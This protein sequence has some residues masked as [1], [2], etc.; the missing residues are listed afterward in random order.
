MPCNSASHRC[1]FIILKFIQKIVYAYTKV[2]GCIKNRNKM[3]DFFFYPPIPIF[4]RLISVTMNLDFDFS[5]YTSV[6]VVE[7]CEHILYNTR[8]L[9]LTDLS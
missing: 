4:S 6:C 3:G 7:I 5:I 2:L 9:V 8:E 1:V